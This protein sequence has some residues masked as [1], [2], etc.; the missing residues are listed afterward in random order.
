MTKKW[1]AADIPHQPGPVAVVTGVSSGIGFV[2][3][4]GLAHAGASRPARRRGF[5]R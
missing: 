4:R 3:A 5:R 2:A 1:T